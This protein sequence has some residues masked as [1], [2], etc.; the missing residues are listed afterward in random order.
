VSV[1]LISRGTMSGVKLLVECLRDQLDY[2][3][4]SREDLVTLVNEYGEL[5]NRIVANL[6]TATRAYEQFSRMRW[7]YLILMRLALLEYAVGDNL[8]YH[9]YSG[10]LLLPRIKHFIRIRINAPMDLRIKMTMD[11]LSCTKE[12]AQE[13][14]AREDE[15]RVRWARF[16]YGKDIREPTLYNLCVNLEG[17]S[18]DAVC[19]LVE[20]LSKDQ[21]FQATTESQLEVER[22]LMAS[23]VEAAFITDPRTQGLEIAARF[24]DGRVDLV[25]PFVE[26]DR[27]E[28]IKKI[29]GA[30]PGVDEVTYTPGFAPVL[31]IAS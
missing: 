13:Y 17:M 20:H 2:R 3:C 19:S 11:R 27:M 8:V 23:R 7:P 12:E 9:G 14:I 18:L 4:V 29:A 24:A 5:A 16:M 26:D 21:E 6:S 15:E 1:I 31:G 30:I 10:H 22:L 25:G 28:A